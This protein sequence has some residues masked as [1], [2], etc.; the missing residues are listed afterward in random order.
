MKYRIRVVSDYVFFFAFS[1]K[2]HEFQHSVARFA[3]FFPPR[4]NT[5]KYFR[6]LQTKKPAKQNIG[7]AHGMS[8]VRRL[9]QLPTV[10]D[11]PDSSPA[12]FPGHGWSQN[13]PCI[14]RAPF[15]RST[16]P[17]HRHGE[18]NTRSPA[19]FLLWTALSRDKLSIATLAR[20]G[21]PVG[22]RAPPAARSS[23]CPPRAPLVLTIRSDARALQPHQT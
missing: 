9:S 16:E 2:I 13:A 8:R 22:V 14:T 5:E 23:G 1:R 19:I 4:Q 17:T 20:H 7:Q 21:R 3:A 12:S 10:R 11:R 18:V 6:D 15:V